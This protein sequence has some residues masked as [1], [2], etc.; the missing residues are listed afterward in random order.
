MHSAI[1]LSNQLVEVATQP[2][3]SDYRAGNAADSYS[4]SNP[5]TIVLQPVEALVQDNSLA[6]RSSLIEA[7]ELASEHVIIDLLWVERIDAAGVAA[8]VVGA[9][10]AMALGKTLSFQSMHYSIHQAVEAEWEKQRQS[11]FGSWSDRFESN[12]EQFLGRRGLNIKVL[13]ADENTQSK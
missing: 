2:H 4:P 13:G 1:D 9:E 5:A 6:F 3:A 7:L 8:L 12:L 11:R 10:K